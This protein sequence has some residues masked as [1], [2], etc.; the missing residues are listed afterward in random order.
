MTKVLVVEDNKFTR[1]YLENM[2]EKSGAFTL[3]GSLK[4]AEQVKAFCYLNDIEMILMDV[5]TLHGHSGLTAAETIKRERPEIKI[6]VVTSLVDSAVLAKA[7]QIGV[8]SLWYKDH[9]EEE[10]LDVMRAAMRGERRFP[11]RAPN[12]EVGAAWS[13][14]LSDT[15]K[16]I[17][18]LYIQ[19][20]SYAA[21]GK[22]LFIE[23]A[24]VKYHMNQMIKKCGFASKQQLIAAAIDST[25]VA[26]LEE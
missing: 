26:Q 9:G 4:D 8:D 3:A 20:N 13:D 10:I 24:T 17:L 21:I 18:R 5:Q 19:G 1:E 25:I 12:V 15:Q 7:K 11:D 16:D 14:E 6:V 23:E 22:K 2:I